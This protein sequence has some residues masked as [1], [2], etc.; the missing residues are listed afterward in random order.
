LEGRLILDE[1]GCG[2]WNMAVD[3]GILESFATGDAPTLRFYSWSEPTL[4]LGYFQ[5]LSERQNHRE[6]ESID[7]VR[8]ATGGGAIVHDLELTYS[9]TV[10]PA[11][12]R[13][14]AAAELY[15]NVHKAIVTALSKMDVVAT[16]AGAAA[17][18]HGRDEPFLCFQ[19]RTPEDL[20]VSGYKI[21][22][23]AQRRGST[24]ILQHGSVLI[25]AS[26]A[27]P[28]LPG[29]AE[30]VAANTFSPFSRNPPRVTGFRKSLLGHF[31]EELKAVLKVR[32]KRGLL[33]GTEHEAAERLQSLQY[34]AAIWNAKR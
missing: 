16:R 11:G 6:S 22:G 27:A 3:A 1:P 24:A 25:A 32:W 5:S 13:T 29:I 26:P 8:R 31:V 18:S 17:C 28:Q 7:F 4:S 9:L 33:S 30:L 2:S 12:S 20:I 23:S 34:D 15:H 10:S 19:R 14:G 21:C